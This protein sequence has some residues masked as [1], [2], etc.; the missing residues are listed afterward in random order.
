MPITIKV[1]GLRTCSPSRRQQRKKL[2][3]RNGMSIASGFGFAIPAS[4]IRACVSLYV[5]DMPWFSFQYNG[6]EASAVIWPPP[7]ATTGE[8]SSS[9]SRISFAR[10]KP[11]TRIQVEAHSSR[12]SP[13][14]PQLNA[15]QRFVSRVAL[16][17]P[18]RFFHLKAEEGIE[19]ERAHGE[20][21]HM[22]KTFCI[23]R[24]SAA[25]CLCSIIDSISRCPIPPS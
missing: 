1:I 10:S 18:E 24:I 19:R 4:L 20:S 6:A 9:A 15:G 21:E 7:R 16:Q 2:A 22:L 14:W 17:Q 5:S 12:S 11:C 23:R 3:C 13:K 25:S 8:R